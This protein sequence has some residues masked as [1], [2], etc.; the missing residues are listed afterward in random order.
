LRGELGAEGVLAWEEG[1][2]GE[3][4][5]AEESEESNGDSLPPSL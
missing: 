3:G 5:G 2:E 4:E 1:E